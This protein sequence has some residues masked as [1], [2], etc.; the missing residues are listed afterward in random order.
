MVLLKTLLFYAT[1][2]GLI[3]YIMCW[4]AKF[5]IDIGVVYLSIVGTYVAFAIITAVT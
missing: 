5:T 1:H 2:L 3:K 4:N